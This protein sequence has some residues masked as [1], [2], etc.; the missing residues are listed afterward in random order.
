[1]EITS[2]EFAKSITAHLIALSSYLSEST[3]RAMIHQFIEV[4][5]E[6]ILMVKKALIDIALRSN[7]LVMDFG[8][9]LSVTELAASAKGTGSHANIDSDHKSL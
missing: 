5:L 4:C 9:Q 7:L 8:K 2:F 1:M 6:P 3:S